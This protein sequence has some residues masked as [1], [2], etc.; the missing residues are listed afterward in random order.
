MYEAF[1]K[2][3]TKGLNTEI[4]FVGPTAGPSYLLN[5]PDIQFIEDWGGPNRATQIGL[6]NA[7]GKYN[8]VVS[9]DGWFLPNGLDHMFDMLDSMGERTPSNVVIGKYKEGVGRDMDSDWYYYLKNHDSLK[10]LEKLDSSWLLGSCMLM[11]TQHLIDTFGGFDM[12]FE[13]TAMSAH[14]LC[15]RIQSTRQY[16]FI[17]SKQ[18]IIDSTHTPGTSGDHA[19]I[20]FAQTQVD[21]PLFNHIITN[22]DSQN[23]KVD[24]D[25]WMQAPAI[26]NRRFSTQL[27]YEYVQVDGKWRCVYERM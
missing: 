8:F 16:N 1:Q 9:D 21:E 25:A 10:H 23:I 22:L 26:W 18:Q 24:P 19:P 11:E 17:L 7:R 14:E 12:R 3:N 6:L 27:K 2:A 5:K 4:V 15:C 13:S 20:H